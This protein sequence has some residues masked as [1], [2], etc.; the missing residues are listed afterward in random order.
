MLSLVKNFSKN[1]INISKRHFSKKPPLGKTTDSFA[2]QAKQAY[3]DINKNFKQ[4]LNDNFTPNQLERANEWGAIA[5]GLL[6]LGVTHEI[7]QKNKN[8]L[9]D[10]AIKETIDN[11]NEYTLPKN[12]KEKSIQDARIDI[13]HALDNVMNSQ[14]FISQ[15]RG[16]TNYASP[17]FTCMPILASTAFATTLCLSTG[18]FVNIMQILRIKK[19]IDMRPDVFS[20]SEKTEYTQKIKAVEKHIPKEI[21]Y[22]ALKIFYRGQLVAVNRKL[23]EHEKPQLNYRDDLLKAMADQRYIPFKNNLRIVGWILPTSYTISKLAADDTKELKKDLEK[24]DTFFKHTAFKGADAKEITE[25][26]N[27]A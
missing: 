23:R 10:D 8:H 16:M 9:S 7:Y 2:E 14:E 15:A 1:T 18:D 13:S 26:S 27:K 19:M 5:G 6:A 25:E 21:M 22:D 11:F 12:F 17:F 3:T 20:E 4:K 24:M